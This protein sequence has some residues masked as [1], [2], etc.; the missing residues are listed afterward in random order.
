MYISCVA[1]KYK[2]LVANGCLDRGLI[3]VLGIHI[4]GKATSIHRECHLKGIDSIDS[5]IMFDHRSGNYSLSGPPRCM[6][7]LV[8]TPSR[9][10][11]SYL[12]TAS[13]ASSPSVKLS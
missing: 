11:G 12:S 13:T 9:S 1:K 2:L 6:Q 10:G 5:E 4:R 7:C 8:K 3:G